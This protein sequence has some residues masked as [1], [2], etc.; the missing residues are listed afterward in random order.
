MK[1]QVDPLLVKD[2]VEQVVQN[3]PKPE[4]G[5]ETW[6]YSLLVISGWA[7]AC[8]C[9][10]FWYKDRQQMAAS[11]AETNNT[12]IATKVYLEG[13]AVQDQRIEELKERILEMKNKLDLIEQRL[14]QR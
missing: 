14:A 4:P 9:M 10:G 3:I 1:W 13:R 7:V 12:M 8:V 2:I 5:M 11:F 6:V